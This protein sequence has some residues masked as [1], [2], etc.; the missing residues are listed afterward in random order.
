MANPDVKRRKQ[1]EFPVFARFPWTLLQRTG[2]ID[3]DMAMSVR[4]VIQRAQH[5]PTV[6]LERD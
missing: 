4:E 6:A 3:G 2:V 5:R 1:G